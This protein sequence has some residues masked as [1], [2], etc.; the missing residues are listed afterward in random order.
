MQIPNGEGMAF[1]THCQASGRRC[2]MHINSMTIDGVDYDVVKEN[3][4][5]KCDEC[6]IYDWVEMECRFEKESCDWVCP[7]ANDKRRVILKRR[8]DKK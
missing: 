4:P 8:M 7:L 6:D 5:F 2:A 1:A 3:R